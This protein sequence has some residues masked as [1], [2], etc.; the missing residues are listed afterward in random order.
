MIH[1]FHTPTDG[2]ALP[3]AFTFPFPLH[4]HPLTW[5]AA[6]GVRQYLLTR[7]DWQE[8][9]RQGKCSGGTGNKRCR[10]KT[11]LPG[12]FFGQS[13]RKQPP[14]RVFRTSGVRPPATRR[15]F[16]YEEAEI[17]GINHRIAA[18][19]ASRGIPLGTGRMKKSEEE[20]QPRWLLKTEAERGET[21]REQR[22]RKAFHPKN[23]NNVA[24]KPVSESRVQTVERRLKEKIGGRRLFRHLSRDSDLAPRTEKTR[25][26]ALQLRLFAP[27]PHAQR[28]R[29][30][31]RFMRDFP[32]HS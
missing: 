25:S 2:I 9:L 23:Q 28:T 7:D 1:S 29:G 17:S 27:V 15:I 11:G 13:G 32:L 31:E 14:Y 4:P 21:L 16:P 3:K 6:D 8:E 10:R 30:S 18:M 19:E 24:R 12:R 22:R 20:A 26:A 5:L